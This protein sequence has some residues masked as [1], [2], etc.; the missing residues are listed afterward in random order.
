[1]VN[2]I[3]GVCLDND[4]DNYAQCG[5]TCRLSAGNICGDC[6]DANPSVNPA[7][8]EICD[9]ID[10]NCAGGI[11]E[12]FNTIPEICNGAD[13]NCNGLI[14][15]G[16][17]GGG[18]TC[19]T[20][21]PGVC[22]DGDITCDQG[23]VIC[24]R[25]TGPGPELCNGLDDDCDGVID[26]VVDNDGDAL[27][28]CSDN[29]PDAFNPPEDCDG[30]P[31]TPDEQCDL[32]SD[33]LG[34][35]CDCTPA[36]PL[37]PDPGEVGATVQVTRPGGQTG[38][39]WGAVPSVVRYN[40]YRGYLTQGNP[41]LYNQQCLAASVPITTAPDPLDPRINTMFYYLASSYCGSGLES[42]LGRDSTGSPIPQP[43]TCPAATLDD[44]GDGTEEAADN[45]PGFRNPSQSDVDADAHGDVCDNCPADSNPGQGDLDGDG[46]GDACD[47]DRDGDGVPNGTDNCP[48]VANPLQEDTD[49]DGIGDACDPT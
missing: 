32:D 39:A 3:N 43:F 1:M 20:G 2:V 28:N 42:V 18:G 30:M 7:A 46:L 29:C 13:E 34:D 49:M 16:N 14:D 33:G 6:N 4:N 27:D 37:N 44:D 45:C 17:P 15:E 10:N 41:W 38:I 31:G 40:V 12:G 8:S 48:D 26:E 22:G 36:D 11:D 23:G 19:S 21:E 47:P 9:S 5:A 35:A 25:V 24:L